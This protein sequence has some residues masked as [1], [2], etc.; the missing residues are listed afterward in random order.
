M[1]SMTGRVIGNYRIV[2]KLGEGG[3]GT[4]YR[5]IDTMVEREVALKSLRPEIAAQPGVLERFHREAVVLARLNHPAIAQLYTFF[6][7]GNE[8]FMVMEYVAGQTLEQMIQQR[9]ALP[10]PQ[11][12]SFAL[13]MLEGIGHAHALDILHRDLKPANVI[14]TPS[15]RLK[16]MDF[17]I[18]QALGAARL[19]REGRI[20]GTLEYLAPERIQGKPADARSDLYSAGVV[21]YEMLTGRLPF[22]SDSDYELL[23]AQV[24]KQPPTPRELGIEL[25]AEV[26]SAVMKALE[27]D[28]DRRYRDAASFAAA[29]SALTP[30]SGRGA[31]KAVLKATRLAVEPAA[32]PARTEP[33]RRLRPKWRAATA[34]RT[35]ALIAAVVAVAAVAL[36]F[37]RPHRTA[38]PPPSPE[39]TENVAQ[40]AL[41]PQPQELWTQPPAPVPVAPVIPFKPIEASSRTAPARPPVPKASAPAIPTREP[42]PAP[43]PAAPAPATV[44]PAPTAEV[45]HAAVSALEE[46]DR[47][48]RLNGLLAALRLG[49]AAITADVAGPIASRGVDF[50][51]TAANEAALREA[52]ATPELVRLVAASYAAPKPEPKPAP[53]PAAPASAPSK[54]VKTLADV[55]SVYVERSP[56]GMDRYIKDEMRKQLGGIVRLV[57]SEEGADGIMR[58]AVEARKGGAV[59][60]AARVFGFKDRSVVRVTILEPGSTRV[61]WQQ[62]TGDRKPVIGAFHGDAPSVMA[63]RIVRELKADLVNRQSH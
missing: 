3:M 50:P 7:D 22:D 9:G 33:L 37:T 29:L 12:L 1:N 31:G 47:P 60:G 38:A 16:L 49:G 59:S 13:Q 21:L 25:P 2:D 51:L 62:G 32:V 52:G 27:K 36:T 5:G 30:A 24:Q 6:K 44:P 61:L 4:V 18:A 55:R 41:P 39:A 11:A 57:E 15:G 56:E 58:V 28:P 26:E 19:T 40:A 54:G 42:T 53:A 48:I 35:A 20:V 43:A 63:Q 10:W 17:G 23:M 45:R 14:V 34:M 8:F 46:T